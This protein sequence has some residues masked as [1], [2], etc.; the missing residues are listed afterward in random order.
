MKPNEQAQVDFI[1]DCLRKGE[2]RKVILAK[3]GEKWQST[4][5]RTFDRRLK[6]AEKAAAGQQKRI[7]ALAEEKVSEEA[8]ALKS[9]IMTSLEL[10]LYLSEII[11]KPTKVMK[12]GNSHVMVNEV[13]ANGKSVI[14]ILP[15]D[16]KLKAADLLCK[17][18]GDYAPTKTDV[19]VNE[20]PKIILP[21][22]E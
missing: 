8:D 10:Q 16:T 2:Q 22:S 15:T 19:T 13:T 18:R 12:V 6:Q 20:L 1:A 3:F 14:E 9:A 5:S 7:Q 21:G 4:S 11:R 17:I